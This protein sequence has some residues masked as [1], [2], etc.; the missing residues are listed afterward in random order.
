MG[1]NEILESSADKEDLYLPRTFQN[2]DAT[3]LD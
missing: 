1:P 3:N 2:T